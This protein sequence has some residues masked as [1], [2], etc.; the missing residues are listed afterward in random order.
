MPLERNTWLVTCRVLSS[1]V[2]FGR[3]LI[4]HACEDSVLASKTSIRN[5]QDFLDP[6]R[7]PFNTHLGRV[8]K[9]CTHCLKAVSHSICGTTLPNRR[10]PAIFPVCMLMSGGKYGPTLTLRMCVYACVFVSVFKTVHAIRISQ[11]QALSPRPGPA[12]PA[13]ASEH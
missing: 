10:T 5:A 8:R 2:H 6:C 4:S 12:R 11:L 3:A 13:P 1:N 9:P 7:A